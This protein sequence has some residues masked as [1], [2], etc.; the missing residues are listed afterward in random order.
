MRNQ[1]VRLI[2]GKKWPRV[3]ALQV[4][5]HTAHHVLDVHG[6]LPQIW[7][8]DLAQRLDVSSRYFLKD[9][10]DVAKIGLEFAQHFVNQ[11]PIFDHE[12]VRIKNAGIFRADRLGDTLLHLENLDARLN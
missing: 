7:V 12:Q 10:L 4:A 3:F 8:I 1:N 6:A 11:G 2:D 9:I 5:D